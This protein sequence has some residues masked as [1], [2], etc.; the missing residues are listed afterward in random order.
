MGVARQLYQLQEIDLEVESDR[1]ALDRLVHQLG[2]SR[3]VV[4]ARAG[5]ESVQ[6]QLVEF[7][8]QQHS[9]EWEL[10]DVVGKISTAEEQ[11]YSGRIKNPKELSSLQHEVELLKTRRDQLENSALE[12]M[13]QVE[14]AEASVAQMSHALEKLEAEWQQYQKELSKD[15][16]ALRNEL[17]E[18]EQKR[19]LMSAEIDPG[20]IE[21]YERLW[22]SKK[23]AVARVEQGICRGCRISLP[24]SDL[25]QVKGDNLVPCSSCGRILYLP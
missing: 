15:I 18:L 14:R 1:Q 6:K 5:L 24:S 23:Q 16:A 8:H 4:K 22:K 10:D 25:Q 19:R 20:T 9:A 3:V 21:V 13:N 2:A 7:G 12:I 11:L 17:S